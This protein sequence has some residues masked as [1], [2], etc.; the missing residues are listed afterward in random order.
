EGVAM[1][2]STDV[3]ILSAARTPQGK[4][5]GNL[6]SLRAVDLGAVAVRSAL[7]RLSAGGSGAIGAADVDALIFGQVLQAGAGQNPARQTS[8]AAGL[9]WRVPT[10]TIN[11]V[12]LSGLA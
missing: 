12:C 7:E 2:A 11:K 1:T 3:V 8:I 10:V 9:D 5:K 6:A 4:I